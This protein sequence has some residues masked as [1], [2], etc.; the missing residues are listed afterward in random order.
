MEI[1]RRDFLK[2][3]GALSFTL[4]TERTWAQTAK[5]EVHWLG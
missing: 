3:A 1:H 5:V 2:L 4:A